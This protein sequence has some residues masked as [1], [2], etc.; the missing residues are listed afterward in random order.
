MAETMKCTLFT[1]YLTVTLAIALSGDW[2][3]Q[4]Q[5]V[6]RRVAWTPDVALSA[7]VKPGDTEVV[8]Y[9]ITLGDHA[10]EQKD[11]DSELLMRAENA[12][13]VVIAEI[14]S[15]SAKVVHDDNWV[16]S[17]VVARVSEILKRGEE[18]LNTRTGI[19]RTL[20]HDGGQVVVNGV[21]VTV[22]L[23]PILKVRQRYLMFTV[24]D[25]DEHRVQ[26]GPSFP[27]SPKGILGAA[28]TSLNG[29]RQSVMTGMRLKDVRRILRQKQL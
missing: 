22:G 28:E 29:K 18:P 9:Q 7:V 11:A 26:A 13:S 24:D 2:P 21:K 23:Y 27:I 17:S 12:D 14:I 6:P 15:V 10:D 20:F 8:V 4:D 19:W 3:S 1:A 25:H 16:E 5:S